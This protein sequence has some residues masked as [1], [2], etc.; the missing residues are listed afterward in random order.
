MRRII[1]LLALVSIGGC[2]GG[3][4]AMVAKADSHALSV[5]E[6]AQMLARGKGLPLRTDIAERWVF[7]WVEKSLFADRIVAGDSLLDSAM[8]VEARW[9]DVRNIV[10]GEFLEDLLRQR[11]ALDSAKLDSVYRAGELRWID[12]ILVPA[13]E[14]IADSERRV[15]QQRAQRYRARLRRGVA[16]ERV[17]TGAD[18]ETRRRS[19]S[20]GVITRGITVPEFED[21]AF[22]LGPGEISAITETSFGYHIIRRPALAAIRSAYE[23]AVED[24]LVVRELAKYRDELAVKW[25]LELSNEAPAIMEQAAASPWR[26]K[27]SRAVI[28]TYRGARFTAADFVRWLQVLPIQV[29]E[30]LDVMT[31]DGLRWLAD[32][33]MK[34]ELE[35][36]ETRSQGATLSRADFERVKRRVSRDVTAVAAALGLD[37][38]RAARRSDRERLVRASVMNH[39]T[40]FTYERRNPVNVPPFLADRL[41][42]QSKWRVSYRALDRV[43]DRAAELRAADGGP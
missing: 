33:L 42:E 28:G 7:S 35:D 29:H 3:D 38:I 15:R 36:L 12:H 23:A 25:E 2:N 41:R 24:T 40:E 34:N 19:T 6:L 9:P 11:V 20:L 26:A 39:L 8:V 16:W 10:V 31:D 32:S 4:A 21:V 1:M 14:D 43:L 13:P 17:R 27:Q 5:G 22:A 18:L 30:R 37:S